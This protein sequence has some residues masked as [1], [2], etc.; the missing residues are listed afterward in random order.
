[1]YMHIQG[2]T[3]R[4][5]SIRAVCLLEMQELGCHAKNRMVLKVAETIQDFVD[6]IS[7]IRRQL[8]RHDISFESRDKW[9]H[10]TR[11]KIT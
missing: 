5:T 8:P 10:S 11:K 2:P 3:L 4:A 6:L 9:G 1:M 7:D